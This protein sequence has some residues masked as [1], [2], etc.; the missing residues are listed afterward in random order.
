MY[1]E[2]TKPASGETKMEKDQLQCFADRKRINKTFPMQDVVRLYLEILNFTARRVNLILAAIQPYHGTRWVLQGRGF[3]FETPPP[4]T[5][6]LFSNQTARPSFY[7]KRLRLPSLESLVNGCPC[8]DQSESQSRNTVSG[9]P[10]LKKPRFWVEIPPPPY[11]LNPLPRNESDS[12]YHPASSESSCADD[13]DLPVVQALVLPDANPN[14]L[15]DKAFKFM[16]SYVCECESVQSVDRKDCKVLRKLGLHFADPV[17]Q[18]ICY[19]HAVLVID[20]DRHIQNA[21]GNSTPS[22]SR[23]E[24]LRMI[25]HVQRSFDIHF[26]QSVQSLSRPAT[27]DVPLSVDPKKRTILCRYR[28]PVRGCDKFAAATAGESMQAWHEINKHINRDHNHSIKSYR[29]EEPRWTQK[30]RLRSKPSTFAYFILPKDYCPDSLAVLQPSAQPKHIS[31]PRNLPFGAPAVF[32]IGSNKFAG[33]HIGLSLMQILSLMNTHQEFGRP[34]QRDPGLIGRFLRQRMG[35]MAMYSAESWPGGDT[36]DN[37]DDDE[38]EDEDALIAQI[39]ARQKIGYEDTGPAEMCQ[40]DADRPNSIIKF[41]DDDREWISPAYD[42]GA[43]TPYSRNC[44]I[45]ASSQK[46][47]I[48]EP[49]STSFAPA[50]DGYTWKMMRGV[51]T[52]R[53]INLR[54]LAS[55]C[56][57][58]IS[59]FE[60][61]VLRRTWSSLELRL[62]IRRATE[63]KLGAPMAPISMRQFQHA[64][65]RTYLPGLFFDEVDERHN[66]LPDLDEHADACHF[67]YL[68]PLLNRRSCAQ[69]L[70]VCQGWQAM[71]EIGSHCPEWQSIGAKFFCVET[72]AYRLPALQA[73]YRIID[74]A[75]MPHAARSDSKENVSQILANSAVREVLL[76]PVIGQVLFGGNSIR[77]DS[78]VPLFGLYS[79]TVARAIQLVTAA[80]ASE[81]LPMKITL[82]YDHF[83]KILE[84]VRQFKQSNCTKWDQLSQEVYRRH[85][86]P[87]IEVMGED[88]LKSINLFRR[89]LSSDMGSIAYSL[90]RPSGAFPVL[91]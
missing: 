30:L 65:F 49:S 68:E 32:P 41:L 46:C 1:E 31:V 14:P 90:V 3:P 48:E 64:V 70:F 8:D 15:P 24:R 18:V 67:P 79:E 56:A 4:S 66:D 57:H 10:S 11:K 28:C 75:K 21:H 45:W 53:V 12:A 22:C 37:Q 34:F 76:I 38:D 89:H 85:K 61:L 35:S 44:F 5:A 33:I 72:E 23:P 74:G 77:I 62:A 9:F 16:D 26:P 83:E 91:P 80:S 54:S 87:Q 39:L 25:E 60:S 51:K 7:E 73:A 58:A 50:A 59:D 71:L 47:A 27:L 78:A 52:S 55:M 82:S 63:K 20:I 19:E 88:A 17:R 81:T 84:G 86:I 40:E 36:A 2:L 43:T 13:E 69:L 6:V 42:E 29:I